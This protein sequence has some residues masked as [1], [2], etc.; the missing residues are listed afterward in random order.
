MTVRQQLIKE[1]EDLPPESQEKILKL[2]HFIKAEILT[3][4]QAKRA[5]KR[6][7]AL[8]KVDDIAIET[9]IPDLAAQH[10]HYLYGLPKK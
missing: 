5:T 6:M 3:S 4:Q 8:A 7:S 9:G 2:V 10:D 1:I